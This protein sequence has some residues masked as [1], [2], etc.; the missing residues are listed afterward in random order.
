MQ[1]T[2]PPSYYHWHFICYGIPGN[3]FRLPAAGKCTRINYAGVVGG[4]TK[5]DQTGI[6]TIS[7]TIELIR[8]SWTVS[9]HRTVDGWGDNTLIEA[10]NCESFRECMPGPAGE[11]GRYQSW[12]YRGTPGRTEHFFSKA[13]KVFYA[14]PSGA[15]AAAEKYSGARGTAGRCCGTLLGLTVLCVAAALITAWFYCRPGTNGSSR[16][17]GEG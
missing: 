4:S 7:Q 14:L 17:K 5:D 6:A 15:V 11:V 13:V 1:K 8:P 9:S 2:H 12:R 10:G 16:W 3:H